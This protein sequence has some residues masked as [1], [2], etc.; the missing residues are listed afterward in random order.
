MIDVDT[1]L[2]LLD[3]HI[4]PLATERVALGESLGRVAARGVASR[5]DLP[6]FDQSAMDGWAVRADDVAAARA[7]APVALDVAG[8]VPAGK[9]GAL[10]TVEPGQAA[11]IFTG[12]R[13]PPGAD[14]VIRQERV[15]RRG[16]HVVVSEP[17]EP[18]ND[19][20]P[21][22]AE[23]ERGAQ[24][25]DAG[26]RLDEGHLGVL[27]M[28]GHADVEV[29]RRPAITLLVS[30]DEVVPA[31]KELRPGQVYDANAPFLRGW[32]TARGYHDVYVRSLADDRPA[33][34]RALGD[35][36]DKSDLVVSTGGV[37][38]GDYDFFNGVAD[39]L[40]LDTVFWR[41]RQAPGKPLLFARR[42]Q[43]C[44]LG[45]PGNPGAVFTSAYV[46]LRRALDLLEGCALPGPR[47]RRGVLAKDVRLRA[48]RLAWTGCTLDFTNE[49]VAKLTPIDGHRMSALY[50]ADAIARIPEGDGALPAGAVVEWFEIG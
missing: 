6:P 10:A 24:L 30:G 45:I 32:L 19:L 43:T 50:R 28:C 8:E 21:R 5:V 35:A 20:R 29:T 33:V 17:A 22:G 13:V 39:E 42:D 27:S 1:A 3:E 12:A 40:G 4:C 18:G 11:R 34:V 2:R 46:Y 48:H 41:V 44:F 16:D 14:A 23:L 31:D 7:D 36:L 49:G 9:T 26:T 37:S 15:E 38:V 47:L 25:I